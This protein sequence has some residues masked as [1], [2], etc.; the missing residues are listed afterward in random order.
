MLHILPKSILGGDST[1]QQRLV[2][3]DFLLQGH[4]LLPGTVQRLGQSGQLQLKICV[5]VL[6]G[7]KLFA[8]LGETN[9]Q[10]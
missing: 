6:G 2:G 1:R 7:A 10:L 8:L 4:L 3:L 5:G 9:L